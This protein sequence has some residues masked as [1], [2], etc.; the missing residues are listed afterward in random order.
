MSIKRI[1]KDTALG[2]VKGAIMVIIF[3]YIVPYIISVAVGLPIETPS[4]IIY[5][6]FLAL[7]MGIGI[8]ERYVIYPIKLPIRFLNMMLGIAILFSILGSGYVVQAIP[9]D[10]MSITVEIDFSILLYTITVGLV[11]ISIVLIPRDED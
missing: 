1:V 11:L 2:V 10:S 6:V 5:T 3:V 7:F 9:L 4:P 8:A